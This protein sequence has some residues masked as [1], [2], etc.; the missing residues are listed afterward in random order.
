MT[1]T[2]S[3]PETVL[4]IPDF[5]GIAWIEL[6]KF[7]E[8]VGSPLACIDQIRYF[9]SSRGGP[10]EPLSAGVTFEFKGNSSV[11]FY[12]VPRPPQEGPPVGWLRID[13]I[14]RRVGHGGTH[15]EILQEFKYLHHNCGCLHCPGRPYPYLPAGVDQLFFERTTDHARLMTICEYVGRHF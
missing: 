15:P 7:L 3:P 5:V 12:F 11:T 13:R 10:K 2:A 6:P 1:I 8:V 9:P 4:D 14:V